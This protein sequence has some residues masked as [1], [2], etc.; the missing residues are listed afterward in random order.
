[1][2]PL[3]RPVRQ[4]LAL[5]GL[6]MA[7]VAAMAATGPASPPAPSSTPASSP[8]RPPQPPMRVLVDNAI[9]MPQAQIR[10][11]QVTAG[12]QHDVAREL[13]RR[14]GREVVFTPVP[15]RR[16]PHLLLRGDAD[17]AC[18]YLPEWLPGAFRWTRPFL[19]NGSQLVTATR[20]PAP[21]AL[22]DLAGTPI[23]T[24][25]GFRYPELDQALGPAFLRDDAPNLGSSLRKLAAGRLDHIV[26][27]I[28]T[29]DYLRRRGDVTVPTH[30]PLVFS[31][32]ATACAL[33]PQSPLD[34]AA[35]DAALTAMQGDGS[36]RR[37]LD[38]YR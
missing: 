34:L 18:N 5:A 12:L 1:M 16:L 23:G 6:A 9:E 36:L 21:Q 22:A 25:A 20:A 19:D 33:S 26:V 11:S 30:P 14:L 4:G 17:L 32:F 27:G 3:T 7:M 2:V 31:H 38:R 13:G 29:Y 35:V 10:G 37:L 24:V 28:L 8:P 15:R